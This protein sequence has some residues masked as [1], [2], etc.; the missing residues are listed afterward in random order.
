MDVASL[1]DRL[2]SGGFEVNTYRRM[3]PRVAALIAIGLGVLEAN[4]LA[5]AADR[6]ARFCTS[7]DVACAPGHNQAVQLARRWEAVVE[8]RFDRDL[9]NWQ[10]KN[11]QQALKIEVAD[12]AALGRSL[13][14]HRDDKEI[15]TAFELT[16]PPIPVAGAALCRLTIAA[17][18]TLD[19]SMAQG[20]KE[21][22][23]NQIRW[24]DRG[25]PRLGGHHIPFRRS[26]GT[27]GT[28]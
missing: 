28:T 24:L 19:L 3:L 2:V 23:Q 13:F 4:P 26:Q 5:A 9:S 11:Y 17:A 15:D 22:Y 18:H 14:V 21:S 10:I 1:H 8:W 16:A 25:R 20:H 27:P 6:A 12:D 7:C